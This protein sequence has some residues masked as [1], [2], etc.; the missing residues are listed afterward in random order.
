MAVTLVIVDSPTK[1]SVLQ[2]FAENE[3]AAYQWMQFKYRSDAWLRETYWQHSPAA[4]FDDDDALSS[5]MSAVQ[6]SQQVVFVTNPDAAGDSMTA[7]LAQ[8]CG[9]MH[10]KA[11]IWQCPLLSKQ[12]FQNKKLKKLSHRQPS[13]META[14]A[15]DRR[16]D[17]VVRELQHEHRKLPVFGAAAVLALQYVVD[18]SLPPAM[19]ETPRLMVHFKGKSSH[20]RAC[21]VTIKG[22]P[23]VIPDDPTFKAIV[24]HLKEKEFH[25][26]KREN[27]ETRVNAPLMLDLGDLLAAAHRHLGFSPSKTLSLALGL[28]ERVDVAHKYPVGLIT[29]PIT[30]SRWIPE[31]ELLKVREYIYLQYGRDYLPDK[32]RLCGNSPSNGVGAVRPVSLQRSPRKMKKLLSADELLLYS[33]IWDSFIKSQMTDVVMS[34]NKLVISDSPPG[35]YK[36]WSE[37][38]ITAHR[39]FRSVSEST[40]HQPFSAAGE[41]WLVGQKLTPA[42]IELQTVDD[43]KSSITEADLIE[44]LNEN[45]ICF[46]EQLPLIPEILR[47][48]NLVEDH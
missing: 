24:L 14:F 36:F 43:A 31:D 9:Q 17:A 32:A 11:H 42:E 45:Q 30:D 40:D 6:N 19:I 8:A 33:L 46:P 23:P 47:Q 39:G 16:I 20:L 41:E 25:I 48:W 28:Y 2:R 18:H 29:F 34:S 10:G 35:F 1:L 37:N 12:Q 15:V 22:D 26:E 4:L 13:L 5:L 38:S 3:P 7:L 44:Y 27:D 21:L